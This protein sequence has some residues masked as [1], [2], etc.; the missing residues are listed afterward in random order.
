MIVYKEWYDYGEFVDYKC[1]GFF[2]FGFIPIYTR[3]IE[4]CPTHLKK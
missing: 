3:R 2:L 1:S 4:V